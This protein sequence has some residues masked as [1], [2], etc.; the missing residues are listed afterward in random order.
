MTRNL[1]EQLKKLMLIFIFWV[2][3]NAFSVGCSND[4]PFSSGVAP[5]LRVVEHMIAD[6]E[7]VDKSVLEGCDYLDDPEV[8]FS[9]FHW[10]LEE[11]RITPT[12]VDGFYS[13]DYK[14]SIEKIYENLKG[15]SFDDISL[16]EKTESIGGSLRW[17]YL[18][19]ALSYEFSGQEVRAFNVY[20]LL[21]GSSPE[22]TWASLRL[23]YAHEQGKSLPPFSNCISGDVYQTLCEFVPT[24][25][26]PSIDSVVMRIN[27]ELE[28]R[29][30]EKKDIPCDYRDWET[31]DLYR[32]RDNCARI[33]C[34]DLHHRYNPFRKDYNIYRKRELC[35]RT[36]VAYSKFIE[37]MERRH[38]EYMTRPAS[39][40]D[41][42][43]ATKTMEILRK[44]AE[45]PY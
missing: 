35:V 25:S 17:N 36:R 7:R 8:F 27:A 20:S 10:E 23:G 31:I 14:R 30:A 29:V 15:L 32:F 1:F 45:L 22:M 38:S 21:Y 24:L 6:G 2:L 4:V 40:I 3:G 33:V 37:Y 16:F 34:P 44:I 12:Q 42:E 19:L 13:R 41:L 11:N 43:N 9:N 28:E 18:V 26:L 5:S 39:L